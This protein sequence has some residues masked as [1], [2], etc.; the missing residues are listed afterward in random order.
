MS[1]ATPHP[2]ARRPWLPRRNEPPLSQW[3][4]L[5][6]REPEPASSP[7]PSSEGRRPTPDEL[8]AAAEIECSDG[9][10]EAARR[11]IAAAIDGFHGTGDEWGMADAL[12]VQGLVARVAGEIENAA[13]CY[14]KSLSA[15]NVL[16]DL[17]STIRLYRALAEARFVAGDF[18]AAAALHLEALA[19][20]PG[21]P[22]LLTGLGYASWYEGFLADALTYL[23]QALS[24][25]RDNLPAL[26]ARGQVEADLGRAGP[27]LADLDQALALDI[28]GTS[29]EEAD[30]RSARALALAQLG[31]R[32]EAEAELT[33]ALRLD[34]ARARTQVRSA[35]ISLQQNDPEGA[36]S[37]LRTA[38]AAPNALPPAHAAEAR[39]RLERLSAPPS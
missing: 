14:R 37:A 1:E 20:L 39:R 30:L 4:R 33:E 23:T 11:D 26:S 31:R 16:G 35:A 32:A 12:A 18:V 25:D 24:V 7:P 38:L 19:L 8:R 36:R 5:Q 17:P 28:D 27:A 34:P 9:D 21:D 3:Y 6:L 29:D 10:L 15:F 13:Q 2:V 22:V